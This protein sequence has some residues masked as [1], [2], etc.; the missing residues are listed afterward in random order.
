MVQLT[1]V[2]NS[3][4]KKPIWVNRTA[5]VTGDCRIYSLSKAPGNI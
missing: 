4:I 1:L 5:Y 2:P 3:I